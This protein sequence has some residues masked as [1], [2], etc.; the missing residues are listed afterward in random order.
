MR[1]DRHPPLARE[2]FALRSYRSIRPEHREQGDLQGS[3]AGAKCAAKESESVGSIEHRRAQHPGL[4][5]PGLAPTSDTD[6]VRGRDAK[7]G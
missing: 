1:K 4:V 5:S 7:R 2:I 3:I 6:F